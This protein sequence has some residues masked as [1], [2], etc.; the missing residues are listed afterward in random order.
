MISESPHVSVLHRS[1]CLAFK[2]V[3]PYRLRSH[4]IKNTCLS[5]SAAD[6]SCGGRAHTRLALIL[7]LGDG[8]RAH[9]QLALILCLGDGGRAH[10]Q[11]ALILCMLGEWR[12][13][14]HTTSFNTLLGGGGRAHTQLALT[15]CLGDGGRAHTQ[16]ALTL[17]MLGGRR[18]GAHYPQGPHLRNP[19]LEYCPSESYREPWNEDR[20]FPER[21]GPR[22]GPAQWRENGRRVPGGWGRGGYGG[23]SEGG[24]RPGVWGAAGEGRGGGE[25]EGADT[26]WTW[27]GLVRA[28]SKLEMARHVLEVLAR[29]TCV[30]WWGWGG[31]WGGDDSRKLG[32]QETEQEGG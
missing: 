15:L 14:A 28:R 25:R 6:A 23:G 8:G 11:L 13:G 26:R 32:R 19:G 3:Q 4:T 16:L 24:R 12:Q 17:C 1:A 5:A 31:G 27:S 20:R 21:G 9:T 2:S 29:G 30:F 10:T 22:G 18:Q 7:C